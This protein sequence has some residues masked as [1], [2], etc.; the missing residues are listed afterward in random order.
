MRY[1]NNFLVVA[2]VFIFSSCASYGNDFDTSLFSQFKNGVTT[3]T[4]IISLV[5]QPLTKT[6]TG[7]GETSLNWSFTHAIINSKV[8]SKIAIAY[9]DKND[10]LL[11]VILTETV[12]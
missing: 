5:G 7:N 6:S 1:F 12:R 8:E 2:C 3:K 10:I 4:E 11:R 9:F